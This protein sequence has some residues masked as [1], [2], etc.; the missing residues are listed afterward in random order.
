LFTATSSRP[1]REHACDERGDMVGVRDVGPYELRLASQRLQFLEDLGTTL[2]A[3]AG[4]GTDA[5]SR[6]KAS[7]V[8]RPI[9]E[10][11]SVTKATLPA[12]RFEVTVIGEVPTA[13]SRRR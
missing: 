11:A 8:A 5:P 12:N 1:K 6:A 2:V 4:D 13:S 3:A 10:L 9:P 7:A